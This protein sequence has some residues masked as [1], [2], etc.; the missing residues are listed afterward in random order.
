MIFFL[1]GH[2][3]FFSKNVFFCFILLK[4]PKAFIWGIIFFC[5]MDGFFRILEKTSSELIC[6]RLYI[7]LQRTTFLWHWLRLLK[8]IFR[9]PNLIIINIAGGAK[10]K[11]ACCAK[12]AVFRKTS[13]IV[14]IF[15]KTFWFFL[16]KDLTNHVLFSYNHSYWNHVFWLWC[17]VRKMDDHFLPPLLHIFIILSKLATILENDDWW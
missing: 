9:L 2:F 16:V 10:V 4:R 8:G 1:G 15:I 3:D 14:S 11:K 7:V 5:T 6:T 12:L 17:D 13:T